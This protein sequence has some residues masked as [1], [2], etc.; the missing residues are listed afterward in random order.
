MSQE[1]QASSWAGTAVIE[2]LVFN[3]RVLA[4]KIPELYLSCI[5]SHGKRDKW[6]V[7]G[8]SLT[9]LFQNYPWRPAAGKNQVCQIPRSFLCPPSRH[10]GPG[11]LSCPLLRFRFINTFPLKDFS[12]PSAHLCSLLR[13]GKPPA[14]Q[15][16]TEALPVITKLFW[17]SCNTPLSAQHWI[18]WG[19]VL[20]G[21]EI[22]AGREEV[23]RGARTP[24]W[25][26]TVVLH[27]TQHHCNLNDVKC[28]SSELSAPRNKPA[29]S[30][31]T[32]QL[33]NKVV[34][35]IIAHYCVWKSQLFHKAP[36]HNSSASR[37]IYII[38]FSTMQLCGSQWIEL[39]QMYFPWKYGSLF[40]LF[41]Q[42][43]LDHLVSD[44]LQKLTLGSSTHQSSCPPA[45][46]WKCLSCFLQLLSKGEVMSRDVN[47]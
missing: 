9:L 28:S 21:F 39:Y 11:S 4:R 41:W 42:K 34:I 27:T 36:W 14:T 35:Y 10:P 46:L 33:S 19:K 29:D 17:K 32:I 47:N 6:D 37:N 7:S 22:I 26:K 24:C 31:N 40:V 30:F 8:L 1:A 18:L 44:D 13:Q 23:S 16:F 25:T 15:L 5:Q 45:Q 38:L 43:K 3:T 2:W 12:S 20:P